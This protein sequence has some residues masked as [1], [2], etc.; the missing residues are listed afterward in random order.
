MSSACT[1][2][3]AS[4]LQ[5]LLEDLFSRVNQQQDSNGSSSPAG[6]DPVCISSSGISILPARVAAAPAPVQLQRSSSSDSGAAAE[7][8]KQA[9]ER[10]AALN[11]DADNAQGYTMSQVG[12]GA[13]TSLAEGVGCAA[14]M[15][16]PGGRQHHAHREGS[17]PMD[18]SLASGTRTNSTRP[19]SSRQVCSTAR[20][21]TAFCW[22]ALQHCRI[23][24]ASPGCRHE[25]ALRLHP[26]HALRTPDSHSAGRPSNVAGPHYRSRHRRFSRGAAEHCCRRHHWSWRRVHWIC[27]VRYH[28]RDEGG[29]IIAV[30]GCRCSLQVYRPG[31]SA[32]PAE[33][34]ATRSTVVGRRW[35][36]EVRANGTAMAHRVVSM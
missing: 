27:L 16:A 18:K 22:Q 5:E 3:S 26:A 20:S 29:A 28:D 17:N 33:A 19:C 30:G 15:V 21:S 4:C 35:C 7:A 13:L 24:I 31:C 10:A 25:F 34:H 1:Q 11:A 2:G 32:R 23:R 8:A 9:A 12:R 14:C 36:F 6:T